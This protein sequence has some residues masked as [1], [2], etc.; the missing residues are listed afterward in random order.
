MI[1][2]IRKF[3]LFEN[4]NFYL[5]VIGCGIGA[6]SLNEISEAQRYQSNG[7]TC[8]DVDGS[9]CPSGRYPEQRDCVPCDETGYKK[10]SGAKYLKSGSCRYWQSK[11]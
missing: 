6:I 8:T 9:G 1:Y 10:T 2:K 4:S 3:L 7:Y 5:F 11:F